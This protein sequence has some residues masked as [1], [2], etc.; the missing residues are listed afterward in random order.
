M[1]RK[2]GLH[3]HLCRN[4]KAV[5]LTARYRTLYCGMLMQKLRDI[6]KIII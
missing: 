4:L 2:T 6:G 3:Q 5:S 1:R